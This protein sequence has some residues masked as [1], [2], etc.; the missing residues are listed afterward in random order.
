MTHEKNYY[1]RAPYISMRVSSSTDISPGNSIT[2]RFEL[3]F[4]P[5]FG[6]DNPSL[7][8]VSQTPPVGDGS[9]GLFSIAS[10]GVP[11]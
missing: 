5:S 7:L 2:V 8:I 1:H 6:A 9:S 4:E 11:E 3:V 10:V